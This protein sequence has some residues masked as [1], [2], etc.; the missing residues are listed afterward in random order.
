MGDAVHNE[1]LRDILSWE[2]QAVNLQAR[3]VHQGDLHREQLKA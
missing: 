3:G 2:V 1:Q